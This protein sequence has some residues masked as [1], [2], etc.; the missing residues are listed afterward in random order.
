M[1]TNPLASWE[2]FVAR[3]GSIAERATSFLE[4]TGCAFEAEHSAGVVAEARR[5]ALRYGVDPEQAEAGAWLHDVSAPIPSAERIALA[6]A[7]GIEVLP[8][9]RTFPM[10]VH[11]RI[12]AVMARDLFGVTDLAVLSA[13]GCHTTLKPGAT[14][15][16]M[17]VFVADK[18]AWDQPGEPPYL[19][20][21]LTAL[22]DSLEAASWV[23]LDH[24]WQRRA[25]L[26]VLHPWAAAAYADL[27]SER[28]CPSGTLG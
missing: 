28:R 11:Q 1:A 3:A 6:E 17:T 9:E 26:P 2:S 21:L 19:P 10:I 18:I 7:F 5:I 16:D 27:S 12:S 22:G 25:E 24:L 13:I 4:A 20:A 8:E 15:L 14:P 23:Y